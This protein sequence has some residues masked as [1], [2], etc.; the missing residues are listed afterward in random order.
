MTIGGSRRGRRRHSAARAAPL[1]AAQQRLDPR[2]ELA[3]RERLGHVVVGADA[4]ADE[5][6]GLVVAGGEHEDRD[7]ALG[8]D[9]AA[10]LEA[11][12]AGQHDVEHDD[13]GVAAGRR[14][15]RRPGRRRRP[16][17][18]ALGGEPLRDRVRRSPARP[19]RRAR[20]CRLA[21][22]ARRRPTGRGGHGASVAQARRGSADH[23]LSALVSAR[24]AGRAPT[25]RSTSHHDAHLP[26]GVASGHDGP[27]PISCRPLAPFRLSAPADLPRRRRRTAGRRAVL[28][29]WLLVAL[30]VLLTARHR[31][32]RRQRVLARHARPGRRSSARP[33]SRRP[34]RRRSSTA[35][36]R[37]STELLRR[38]GRHHADHDPARATPPSRRSSLLCGVPL[39]AP[40]SGGG[41]RRPR[42]RPGP[43]PRQRVLDGGRRAD[44]QE[45]RDLRPLATARLVAPLQRGVHHRRSGRSSRSFNGSANALLRRVGVE[46]REELSGARSPQ[47]LAVAGAALGGG[48]HARRVDR[49][50]ADQLASSF[51]ELTAVDVMTDRMRMVVVRA[52]TTRPRTSSSSR[53]APGHSRFP[54]IGDDRRRRRRPRAP[55]PRGR[56]AARPPGRGARG[57]PHGRRA[58]ACPRRC[59]SARCWSSC[60]SSAC[61]WRWSSTSTAAR[62]ASSRSRTSSRSSWATSPTSTTPAAPARPARRGRL[63][64]GARRAASRRAGRAHR[65]GRCPRT[66]RTRPSAGSSWP[67]WA[68]SRA[69]ATR[70]SSTG[71]R[72]AGRGHGGPRVERVRVARG[73]RPRRPE[74]SR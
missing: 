11:V 32:V 47:E 13:V 56:R 64:A 31:G 67:S 34:A 51:T 27:E 7:R 5:H 69:W 25:V 6:V 53:G 74:A 46:P 28:T 50:A 44:P 30:G 33:T 24:S 55:A 59:A 43:R 18:P 17:P 37:L 70:S 65:A 72:P 22:R 68:G 21:R 40:P 19:R 42:R 23:A 10:D 60:A 71:V 9:A 20:S 8:L 45:L 41:R 58:R 66:A 2:D 14:R 52:R 36:R 4:E 62:P 16:R 3:H 48:G 57:R 29:E 63:V 49:D 73:R 26:A 39:E 35:L 61:R 54:V 12:D 1:D 38:P 15:R